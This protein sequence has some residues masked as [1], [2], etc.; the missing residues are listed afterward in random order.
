MF[1]YVELSGVEL[2]DLKDDRKWLEGAVVTIKEGRFGKLEQKFTDDKG[3]NV[4]RNVIAA[5]ILGI[6]SKNH[7]EIRIGEYSTGIEWDNEA[8]TVSA[9]GKALVA[10]RTL[11]DNEKKKLIGRN[12]PWAFFLRSSVLAGV[13]QSK[14]SVFRADS[15]DGVVFQF[16]N[17]KPS[18]D[19]RRDYTVP[20]QL[21]GGGI[22]PPTIESAGT[23]PAPT[24]VALDTDTVAA[25]KDAIV[26]IV[27]GAKGPVKHMELFSQ[28]LLNNY[29]GNIGADAD[30]RNKI[31]NAVWT[32]KE[33]L[34]TVLGG[35]FCQV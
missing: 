3:V 34:S 22:V 11:T 18:K 13:S 17:A 26:S 7:K 28:G 32:Q 16:T 4:V 15:I 14:V 20:F 2:D 30:K 10:K 9:D 29:L 6:T 23:A 33:S 25:V 1:D 27:S 5:K 35:K 21:Q 31:S 8:V 12:A 19:S 24:A